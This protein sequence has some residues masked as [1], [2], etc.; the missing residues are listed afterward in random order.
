M[1]SA[2]STTPCPTCGIP[3]EA[4]R[5][6]RCPK[7]DSPIRGQILMGLLEVDVVH[8]GEDWETARRKIEKAVDQALLMGNSGVKIIHGYGSSTGRSIIASQATTLMR[9]LA[10]RTGGTFAT[11]RNNRGAHLI[12]FNQ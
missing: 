3:L 11:D 12:W 1:S 4:G 9:G 8:S 7:C 2:G 6:E 5:H 10:E